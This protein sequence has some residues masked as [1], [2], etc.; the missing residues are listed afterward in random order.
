MG[1][2]QRKSTDAEDISPVRRF[3]LMLKKLGQFRVIKVQPHTVIIDEVE[4][5][6]VLSID[7]DPC[8]ITYHYVQPFGIR[9]RDP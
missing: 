7:C 1:P 6:N 9:H 2:S 8:E 5:K 3:K 4:V